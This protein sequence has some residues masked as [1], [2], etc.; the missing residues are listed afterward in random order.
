LRKAAELLA[1]LTITWPWS[2]TISRS[3]YRCLTGHLFRLR[4]KGIVI[5][6]GHIQHRRRVGTA[7]LPIK[8]AQAHKQAA[9]NFAVV[10]RFARR[11]GRRPVPL[12]PAARVGNRAVLF[13]ETGGRQTEDFGLDIFRTTS[14]ISPWFCQKFDDCHQRV[15]HHQ[16]LQLRQRG[17]ICS[18]QGT[19]PAG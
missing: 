8:I 2:S 1:F 12:Q 6:P 3:A 5:I 17:K 9:E 13:G 15:N 18:Y 19:P 7:F 10:E 11:F 16:V 4:V 14:F